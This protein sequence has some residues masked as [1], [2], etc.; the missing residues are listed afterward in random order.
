MSLDAGAF[1]WDVG[2]NTIEAGERGF[3]RM[4]N[5]RIKEYTK[6]VANG[7]TDIFAE[8]LPDSCYPTRQELEF[9]V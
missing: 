8:R 3:Q 4:V 2:V 9:G 7:S 5:A 1:N 6:R